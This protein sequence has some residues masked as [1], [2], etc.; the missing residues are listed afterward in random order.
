MGLLLIALILEAIR[1]TAGPVLSLIVLSFLVYAYLGEYL[2]SPWTHR[3]YPLDRI[4]GRM[5]MTLEGIFGVPTDVAATFIILFTIYGA[6]LD[7]SGA[8]K[9]FIDFSCGHGASRRR[10]NQPL[11]SSS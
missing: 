9:F 1:R 5:Y 2:P 10:S 3:G 7:K 11:A 4:V 6:F 8:G